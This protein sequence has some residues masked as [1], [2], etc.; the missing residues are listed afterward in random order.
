VS[1]DTEHL[2]K[3][4]KVHCTCFLFPAK[5]TLLIQQ[6]P[7]KKQSIIQTHEALMMDLL[8][9]Q[10]QPNW[11]GKADP[12]LMP[13]AAAAHLNLQPQ[14][15][16]GLTL[17]MEAEQPFLVHKTVPTTMLDEH[18][19]PTPMQPILHLAGQVYNPDNWVQERLLLKM[20]R[21]RCRLPVV[22]EDLYLMYQLGY[23]RLHQSCPRRLPIK[24]VIEYS[25]KLLEH[26]NYELHSQA[27]LKAA[28]YLQTKKLPEIPKEHTCQKIHNAV[29]EDHG[30]TN[31]I[32]AAYLQNLVRLLAL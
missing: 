25:S 26:V 7:T 13:V 12:V 22:P 16:D 10:K 15:L 18:R 20:L 31:R 5:L 27:R 3:L 9:E 2:H 17:A 28:V 6:Q 11:P 24:T 19:Y 21:L 32:A 23:L 4:W 1:L 30:I 8:T 14:I 29:E